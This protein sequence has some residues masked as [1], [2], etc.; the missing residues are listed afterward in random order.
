MIYIVIYIV[1]YIKV[2]YIKPTLPLR[3]LDGDPGGFQLLNHVR[4]LQERPH[5]GQLPHRLRS[6]M[7]A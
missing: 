6:A 3:Q 7:K 4:T 5:R 1:I 2:K